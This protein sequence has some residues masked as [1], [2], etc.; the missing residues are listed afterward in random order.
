LPLRTL[1]LGIVAH[2]DAGKT[3][4]TERLLFSA[5]VLDELGSVDDGSTHTDSL[6]LEQQRG[7]TIRAA[8]ASF[9]LGDLTVNLV[10]TPG[11]PDFIAE[12]DRVLDVL[13]GA[14]LVV[15]AVEGVQSHT[16]I[17]LRALERLKVPTIL[18]VNKI[19]R[20]GADV[21]RVFAEATTLLT[22]SVVRLDTVT[23]IGTSRADAAAVDPV[24]D[25]T[26]LLDVLARHDAALLETYVEHDGAVSAA[27]LRASLTAAIHRGVVHP[28]CSG[29]ALLG[30]G[31]DALLGHV[32]ALLPAASGDPD[33]PLDGTIFK[34]ERGEHREK[35]CY[36][37]LRS[38]T[39]H[40][41]DRVV[42]EGRR[43][44][45]VTAITLAGSG[46]AGELVAGE[47]GEVLGFGDARIGDRV[48]AATSAPRSGGS[49]FA[50]P[51]LETVVVPRRGEDRVRLGE[52]LS[53]LG[54]Q[55]PL[56][57]VRLDDESGE[58]TVS[59]YGEVQKEVIEA[60]LL[61]DFG[62]EA[63]FSETSTICVERPIGTG[64]AVEF[65]NVAPNP[66]LATIGLRVEPAGEGSGVTYRRDSTIV[67]Q[68]PGAYFKAV[69]DTVHHELAHGLSGWA[70][71]DC[72]VTMTHAGYLG[73]HGLGHQYF[74]K[75]MSSTGE[76]FRKLTPLVLAEALRRAGTV[77]CEPMSWLRLE[78]PT[79]SLEGVTAAMR[80]LRAVTSSREA[81]GRRTVVRG[82]I[83]AG[84]VHGLQVR[85]PDLTRGEGVA[86]TGFDHHVAVK[87]AAPVRPRLGLDPH[88]RVEYLKR[89]NVRGAKA[90]AKGHFD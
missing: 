82:L 30:R 72:V 22:P 83:P 45:A 18:F 89:L 60:T 43:A 5:G 21:D 42:V 14:V 23:D 50:A 12:V 9:S 6:A 47:I 69:E 66:F 33:G 53:M 39:L 25:T 90:H 58:L 32:A 73:K 41:R 1:N 79:D 76:D 61:Q 51:T 75:A 24:A 85:L 40:V 36:V 37:R 56:I 87:G 54:E 68:M 46:S 28:V 88:D 81:D 7:I 59:L 80:Q 11:H 16:R 63:T 38:G 62:V 55:D 44:R 70:V 35:R 49:H 8:V 2:V 77:V 74:N 31:T 3:T 19:D 13:D 29:S 4:L 27:A 71:V 64:H 67:G 65:L 84:N 15:S 26:A 34:I 20:V 86:E 78:V 52:A 57:R 48:G 10:D 17:L